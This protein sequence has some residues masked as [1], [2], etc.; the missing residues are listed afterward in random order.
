MSRRIARPRPTPLVSRSNA[1]RPRCALTPSPAR[2]RRAGSASCDNGQHSPAP[3]CGDDGSCPPVTGVSCGGFAC[4][5]TEC[6]TQCSGPTDCIAGTICSSGSCMGTKANGA[7]CTDDNQCTSNECECAD[8][9]CSSKKCSAVPC[10]CSFNSDGDSSC[11][12][13]LASGVGDASGT[14]AGGS[15]NGSGGCLLANGSVCASASACGSGAASAPTPPAGRSVVTAPLS[16]NNCLCRFDSQGDGTCEGVLSANVDDAT[17]SCGAVTC[18]GSGACKAAN[19][20]ACGG[21]NDCGSGSCAC[22]NATCGAKRCHPASTCVCGFDATSD[23]TCEGTLSFGANDGEN[24]CPGGGCDGPRL[25]TACSLARRRL[26]A[27]CRACLVVAR[28]PLGVFVQ[29]P[30]MRPSRATTTPIAVA[31]M[32]A[33]VAPVSFDQTE[34]TLH[35]RA[36]RWGPSDRYV[37]RSGFEVESP[38]FSPPRLNNSRSPTSH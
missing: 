28:S 4:D 14:C 13:N 24:S 15:C 34:P 19:G 20:A 36:L 3:T 16:P 22:T 33:S 25:T 10:V 29:E 27:P 32:A 35:P 30:P 2:R 11:D 12:G 26:S 18:N 5:G 9:N 17:D 6:K 23:G 21:D 7:A 1:R 37:W 38:I 31:A 8:S